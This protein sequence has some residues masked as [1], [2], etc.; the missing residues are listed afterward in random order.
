M[1]DN[2][3][4]RQKTAS[5][6]FLALIGGILI[7]L[8][9]LAYN[10][11]LGRLDTTAAGTWS[12]SEASK[13]TVRELDETLEIV[14]YFSEELPAQFASTESYVRDIL[15]EY[16]AASSKVRVRFVNPETD[17]EKEQAQED[18]VPLAAWPDISSDRRGTVQGFAGLAFH[19]LGETRSIPTVES[20]EGLE[21]TI[22]MKIKE[23][24]GAETVVGVVSGHGS[25]ALSAPPQQMP[26]QPPAA[27][28]RYLRAALPPYYSLREV[29]LS[30]DISD[31][32]DA[33]LII[34]PT[35]AFSEDELRRLNDFVM[36]GKSLGIFGAGAQVELQGQLGPTVG[37]EDMGLNGLLSQWGVELQG[38]LVLD[39]FY[40]CGRVPVQ[41]QTPFG[42]LQVPSPYPPMPTI[43]FSE[44]NE[45]H[46]AIYRL[47]SDQLPFVSSLEVGSAPDGVTATVLGESSQHS[48]RESA[49]NITPRVQE[50]WRPTGDSGPFSVLVALEG[51]F[52]SAFSDASASES[53]DTAR[54]LISG[55][56]DYFMFRPAL[57]SQFPPPE[58][59][60]PQQLQRIFALALNNIDWLAAES[61]LVALRAKSVDDPPIAI[62]AMLAAEEQFEEARDLAEDAVEEQD[63]EQLEEAQ[64]QAEDAQ[65]AYQAAQEDFD[66]RKSMFKFANMLGIPLVFIIFG[67]IRW[68][69]RQNQRENISL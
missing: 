14:G 69:M 60:N 19:Y 15:S 68:R 67:I 2:Q 36:S 24:I 62:P 63:A 6:G 51:T 50:Q 55:S 59:L 54:V 45:T 25:P 42:T 33:L 44:E 30:S 58:Q 28:L 9:V 61:E 22:T 10:F 57:T 3:R 32:L 52:P 66:S 41:Q 11:N 7:V 17:E 47:S 48:W 20:V 53:P 5:L 31:D 21:Y 65:A 34:A 1:T 12:L 64:E 35:E 13:E 29:D 37:T 4:T 26:G 18:G 43:P 16:E 49:P 56:A 46:P 38:D 27:S 23:L 8:N 40:D 39:C